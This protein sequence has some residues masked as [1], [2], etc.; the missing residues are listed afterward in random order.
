MNEI[1]IGDRVRRVIGDRVTRGA[2]GAVLDIN[3]ETGRVRVA[4]EFRRYI[5]TAV[6]VGGGDCNRTWI[7][8]ACLIAI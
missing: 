2:E 7:K 1:K 6:I 5:G 3:A 4:W 8:A